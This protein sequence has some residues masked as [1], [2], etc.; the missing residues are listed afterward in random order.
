[1]TKHKPKTWGDIYHAACARGEDQ[2]Y[3][4]HLADE[5]E[6]RM[7]NKPVHVCTLE[8]DPRDPSA[9]IQA[10]TEERD[11]LLETVNALNETNSQLAHQL[12]CLENPE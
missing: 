1:M 4:A 9:I 11:N 12:W 8:I 5:W 7:K 2:S 6:K 3:A 10:L